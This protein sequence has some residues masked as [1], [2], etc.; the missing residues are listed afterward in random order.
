MGTYVEAEVQYDRGVFEV[1]TELHLGQV[2]ALTD[3]S[4]DFFVF[5]IQTLNDKDYMRFSRQSQITQSFD[6]VSEYISNLLSNGG[7]YFQIFCNN[8][9]VGTVTVKPQSPHVAEVGILVFRQYCN[10]GVASYVWSRMPAKLRDNNFRCMIAG[11]H[12]QNF[13]MRK[14]AESIEMI[15]D[16]SRNYPNQGDSSLNFIYYRLDL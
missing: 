14:T 7:M 9:I 8:L 10:M 12:I 6:S 5:L 11:T 13:Q 2:G 16:N 3:L 15:L 4:E 1:N